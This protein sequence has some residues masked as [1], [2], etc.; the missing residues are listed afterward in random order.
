MAWDDTVIGWPTSKLIRVVVAADTLKTV[1]Y[2]IG[3]EDAAVVDPAAEELARA[4]AQE[5]DRRIPPPA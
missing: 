1:R 5:L 3:G 2:V 4:C